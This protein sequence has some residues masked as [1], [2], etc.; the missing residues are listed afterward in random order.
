MPSD[1]RQPTIVLRADAGPSI[2]Y[3]HL[4]RTLALENAL[5][6]RGARCV[7]V[8]RPPPGG[9]V[10]AVPSDRLDLPSDLPDSEE[11]PF[12]RRTV[13][14]ADWL[15][16]DLFGVDSDRLS[17]LSGPWR[18]AAIDDEGVDLAGVDLV[19]CPSV[20]VTPRSAVAR[21]PN[22]LAG[23]AHLLLR[24]PFAHPPARSIEAEI[25]SVVVCLG[26]GDSHRI[27]RKLVGELA[28]TLPPS[29]TCLSVI[30]SGVE[31]AD[32]TQPRSG[33]L[34]VRHGLD[35]TELAS[36]MR[37]ADLGV[38]AAGTLLY[39]A[40]ALGLPSVWIGLNA[41]QAREAHTM[42]R[43]GAGVYAGDADRLDE[44]R[45]AA[46]FT[47]LESVEARRMAAKRAQ[48]VVDG[49][50][51]ERVAAHLLANVAQGS[52]GRAS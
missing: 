20:G 45:L 31:S 18:L 27:V 1:P 4:V 49:R 37:R 10:L 15:V 47:R 11:G 32:L 21:A 41:A 51:C 42:E 3:G 35:A 23:A 38:F 26:G 48:V 33:S 29:V 8:T 36:E 34:R 50:G 14:R 19:V 13:V 46:S 2:G 16:A 28:R 6:A 7:L 44:T 43:L 39:E 40:A 22:T 30:A 25:R 5:S 17:C 52:N 12:L 24:A 9:F